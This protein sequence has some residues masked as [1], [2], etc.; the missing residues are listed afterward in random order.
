M[1]N[2]GHKRVFR[3]WTHLINKWIVVSDENPEEIDEVAKELEHV[4][5]R[6]TMDRELNEFKQVVGAE[7]GFIMQFM[8]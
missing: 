6:N 1:K 5:R 2:D 7:R 8:T 4:L 3:V